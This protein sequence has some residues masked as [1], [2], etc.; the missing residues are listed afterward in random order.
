LLPGYGIPNPDAGGAALTNWTLMQWFLE[1]GH[2]VVVVPLVGET[3][4][5][6]RGYSVS[7]RLTNLEA[8]GV[9]VAPLES[10]ASTTLVP[11]SIPIGERIAGVVAPSPES[12]YP[13][14]ADRESMDAHLRSVAADVAFVYH[15]EA[16]AATFG[17]RDTP[18]VGAAVD[19]S[20]LPRYYRW[21]AQVRPTPRAAI[22]RFRLARRARVQTAWMVDLLNDCAA[23]GNF[24]AHHAEW[25]RRHGAKC[26]YLHTPV[27]DSVGADWRAQ[28][29]AALAARPRILLIGHLRGTATLDGLDVFLTE[30][31]PILEYTFGPDGFEVRLAGGYDPPPELA[32]ALDRP[33]VTRLG[34]LENAEQEFLSAHVMVVPT[35]IELGTRVRILSAFSCACAVVAHSANALGIPELVDGENVLLADRGADLAD[36]IARVLR[37]DDLR[38]RLEDG[39]RATFDRS[40]SPPVAAKRIEL[41]LEAVRRG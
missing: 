22:E 28:R 40:F 2:D 19:L 8:L 27:P 37:D 10:R 26:E 36:G 3:Y 34:H 24:A 15:W 39:G 4:Y 11:S 29:D 33:S 5:D 9:R 31:L 16:L 30:V 12:L 13:E 6:P 38:R 14:L 17:H 18:K 32:A 25:L 20:H 21:R 41:L 35:S 1:R 23:A 7:D